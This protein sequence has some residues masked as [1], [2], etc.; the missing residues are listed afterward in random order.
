[1]L[2]RMAA[3]DQV[4]L[5]GQMLEH[6]AALEDLHQAELGHLMRAHA[7]DALVAEL[8]GALGDLAALGAQHTRYRLQG[9]RLAGAVGA[10]ERGDAALADVDRHALQHQ[11]DPVVDDLDI[12]DRQHA[13]NGRRLSMDDWRRPRLSPGYDLDASAWSCFWITER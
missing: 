2:L 12:V 5:G 11:D 3:S 13:K 9:R 6:A 1:M 4:L 10:Q 7:I 8:D